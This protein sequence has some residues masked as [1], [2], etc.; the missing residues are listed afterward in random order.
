MAYNHSSNFDSE[1]GKNLQVGTI[2]TQYKIS[3]INNI[4][5]NE[6]VCENE[7]LV[8]SADESDITKYCIHQKP[9]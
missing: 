6:N 9:S 8:L 2:N 1:Y 5:M 4:I 7:V 3:D